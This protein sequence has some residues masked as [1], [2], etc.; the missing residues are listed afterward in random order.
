MACHLLGAKPLPESMLIYWQ[1]HRLD[2]LQLN[3]NQ[4]TLIFIAITEATPW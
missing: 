4:N 3:F 2:K 1:L